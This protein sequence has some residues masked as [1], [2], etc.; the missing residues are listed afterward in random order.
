[1]KRT[2]IL[3]LLLTVLALGLAA[4]PVSA[5]KPT[6]TTSEEWVFVDPWV[7]CDGFT[8]REESL[9]R[10]TVTR[11]Y[12]N[13][14]ELDR[15]QVDEHMLDGKL[16]NNADPAKWLV[17]GPS[18]YHWFLEPEYLPDGSFAV[19]RLNGMTGKIMKPDGGILTVSAG[20]ISFN[21]NTGEFTFHGRS[22]DEDAVGQQVCDL[23]R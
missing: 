20:N 8:V 9:Y 16:I 1:M 14:G 2:S 4:A 23:L 12:T 10:H 11:F 15:V 17:F 19:G 22:D 21:L 7:E 13:T 3:M 6:K 5:A 18:N